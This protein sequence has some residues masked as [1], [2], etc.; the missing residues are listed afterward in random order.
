MQISF[1]CLF[2]ATMLLL[3]TVAPLH[4]QELYRFSVN[5]NNI[6]EDK[7]EVKLNTPQL[8]SRSLV[9]NIPKVV[10]GT[11]S[12]SDFGR[13]VHNFRA[14]DKKGREL[15]V[16]QLNTNQWRIDKA[17]RLREIRYQVEDTWDTSQDNFIFEPAGTNIEEDL[18]VVLNPFGYFGYFEGY[19]DLP[20]RVSVA[21]PARFYGSTALVPVAG[22]DT[23]DV[24]ETPNYVLL[25]DSPIMYNIP[26]TAVFDA[27]GAEVLV[28]V[29]SPNRL[30]S[31]KEVAENIADVL[32]AQK[33]YLGG[34]LPIDRYA[35]II[36]LTDRPGGSGM[37]GAL[38]H[39]RSSFY[40]LPEISPVFLSQSIRDIAA[41]EFFHIVTPL[42][43]HSEEIQYFD[44]INPKMSRHLWLYEGVTEYSAGHVQIMYDLIDMPQYLE[45]IR[46]K[47]NNAS[48]FN[49]TIP[50]TVMSENVLEQYK[51]EFGNVYE[52]GA[53]IALALDIRLLD[54]SDGTYGLQDLMRD[55]SAEYGVEKPFKDDEL[56]DEIARVSGYAEIRDFFSK[57]VEGSKP[58]P[59]QQLFEKVGIQYYPE[60]TTREVSMG[61][62]LGSIVLSDDTSFVLSSTDELD[63]FGKQM[64]YQEGDKLLAINGQQLSLENV[65]D[66]ITSL[67][68]QGQAGDTLAVEILRQPEDGE[69][70]QGEQKLLLQGTM[71]VRTNVRYHVFEP[72][73]DAAKRQQQLRAAWL[74]PRKK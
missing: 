15:P 64:G 40:F 47:L 74:S 46:G 8:K 6:S 41:H 42:N 2:L 16:T 30:L 13:F 59:L 17:K 31:A 1:R 32:E 60:K 3:G 58:L 49:D 21:K 20:Y 24:F 66:I 48:G 22:N 69:E 14:L 52:K 25:A 71:P 19:K 50:F 51:N 23:L 7:L 55:L 54:L 61:N 62:I 37:M 45:V 36:Y 11:Y 43:I 56:F 12:V 4:A 57:Y 68:E 18:N 72:V 63:D 38:E 9:Y 44:F 73:E 53:L 34:E 65:V 26:D 5:L 35:F 39:M 33:Q 29:Y 10:P 70:S 67:K 27:G 28:S